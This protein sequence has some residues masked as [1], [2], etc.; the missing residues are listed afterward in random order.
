MTDPD[1]ARLSV[2]PS[3]GPPIYAPARS[4]TERPVYPL[5]RSPNRPFTQ[6]S[7]YPP[8]RKSCNA[9][10]LDPVAALFCA[11]DRMR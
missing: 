11:S 8:A 6:P 5:A 1:R 7:V 2:R 4:L 10:E 3:T 9:I